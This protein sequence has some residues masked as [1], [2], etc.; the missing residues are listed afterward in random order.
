MSTAETLLC[1]FMGA[2]AG[3]LGYEFYDLMFGRPSG[4]KSLARKL[5][6][7]VYILAGMIS[8]WIFS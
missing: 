6:P 8:F 1:F 5:L 4:S 3:S 2:A 7:G